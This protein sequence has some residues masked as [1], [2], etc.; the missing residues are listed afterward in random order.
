MAATIDPQTRK[1]RRTPFSISPN[2]NTLFFTPNLER[3]IKH[4]RYTIDYKQG[5]T[6]ILGDVGTGKSSLL[7]YI[8][9]EYDAA[10][11][12]VAVLIA[13]P[14][15]KTEFAMLQTICQIVGITAKRSFNAQMRAFE[16][17]LIEKYA[18]DTGVVL[19]IDESQKLTTGQLELV[20]D[21]L[22]FET[23]EEKLIEI[24]LAGQ[25]EL[26]DR[27]KAPGMRALESRLSAPSLLKPMKREE[28][29][30]MIAHRC[31]LY[32]ID[33]PFSPDCVERIF[34][35]SRGV[36]RAAIRLCA[37]AYSLSDASYPITTDVVDTAFAELQI[38]EAKEDFDSEGIE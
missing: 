24:I 1:K 31:K 16:E 8:W 37:L 11:D 15:F 2:P 18:S 29:A 36:P 27:L 19:F 6:A 12:W 13:S 20:R 5:V 25:I 22:N 38:E 32:D 28:L 10:E 17:W 21:C 34:L 23:N 7:R 35:L 9:N 30:G 14:S 26:R 4:T 3:A 33:N